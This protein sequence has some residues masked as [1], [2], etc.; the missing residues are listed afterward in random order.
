MVICLRLYDVLAAVYRIKYF[1][2]RLLLKA[3]GPQT[4][5]PY[6]MHVSTLI[7]NYGS[8][9]TSMGLDLIICLAVKPP[10]VEKVI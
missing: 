8:P 7:A 6:V 5:Q 2:Y 3:L 10:A 9:R 1:Y 4:F